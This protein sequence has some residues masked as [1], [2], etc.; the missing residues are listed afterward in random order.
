[1]FPLIFT[2]I[3]TSLEFTLFLMCKNECFEGEQAS[4]GAF[5]MHVYRHQQVLF[6]CANVN[7]I[8][9]LIDAPH[10]TSPQ[11]SPHID[12]NLFMPENHQV[13]CWVQNCCVTRRR[14]RP[15]VCQQYEENSDG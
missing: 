1:M 11:P 12:L 7:E 13:T 10:S 6:G 9:N 14:Q 4:T 8:Y 5:S 3:K 2:S 15:E